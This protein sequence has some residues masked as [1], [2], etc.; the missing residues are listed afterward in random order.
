MLDL[1]RIGAVA[2]DCF[3]RGKA[4]PRRDD[5]EEEEEERALLMEAGFALYT[6]LR[7]LHDYNEEEAAAGRGAGGAV[8]S[9]PPLE[10]LGAEEE[11]GG[12]GG[13]GS[14]SRGVGDLGSS[15]AGGGGRGGGGGGDQGDKAS[16]DSRGM[17]RYICRCEIVNAA[18]KLERVYFRMPDYCLLLT[19]ES[20]QALLWGVDRET[21]GKQIQELF[22]RADELMRE[23]M[24]QQRLSKSGVWQLV[25]RNKRLADNLVLSLALAQNAVIVLRYSWVPEAAAHLDYLLFWEGV[26]NRFMGSLQLC[27]CVF[28]FLISAIEKGP[29]R[30]WRGLRAGGRD[31]TEFLSLPLSQWRATD[32][33]RVPYYLMADAQL[34]LLGFLIFASALG[35]FFSPLWF[36]VHLLDVTNKSSDLQNVFR[37]VTLNGRSIAMTALFG[38]I[39]IYL[40]AVVGYASARD[41]FVLGN[42]P[43]EDVP[44]CTSLF[45]CFLNALNE[46]LRS[47]D[48]GSF[49]DPATPDDTAGY[50]FRFFYQL[51]FWIIVI[52]ILLNVIFGIIID[53]FGELRSVHA[54]K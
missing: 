31:P 42:Y 10:L 48:I 2:A 45:S 41:V 38:A 23:M 1:H 32:V 12:D 15:L 14:L 24:H 28:V 3:R 26:A 54:A 47:G 44:M 18:G 39:I 4:P 40:F 13:Q 30:V 22:E 5:E 29:M 50:F 46:G 7:H 19:D 27:A 53:T 37:A 9:L 11:G 51:F 21:P 36:S 34:S 17:G 8:H 49:M 6:L 35:L 20:K 16:P 43:D 25:M 52:T 33:L